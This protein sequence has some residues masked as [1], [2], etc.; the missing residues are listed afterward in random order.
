MNYEKLIQ[1]HRLLGSKVD[2]LTKE[3]QGFIQQIDK[4]QKEIIQEKDRSRN[5]DVEKKNIEN[6]MINLRRE[7]TKLTKKIETQST[8]NNIINTG[9]RS[10]NSKRY[11][12]TEEIKTIESKI[13]S[14]EKESLAIELL[15]AIESIKKTTKKRLIA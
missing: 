6:E 7:L 14:M 15:N 2:I 9:E 12:N 11:S 4:L 3:K 1:D 13:N 5:I 8:T 10:F